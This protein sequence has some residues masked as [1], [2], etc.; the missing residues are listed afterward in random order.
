[1]ITLEGDTPIVVVTPAE[2]TLPFYTPTWAGA[3]PIL[4]KDHQGLTF[5]PGQLVFVY[6]EGLGKD[7]KVSITLSHAEQGQLAQA[8]TTSDFTGHASVKH[9]VR[10]SAEA[11]GARPAGDLTFTLSTGDVSESLTFTIDYQKVFEKP[12][13]AVGIS[14]TRVQSGTAVAFWCSGFEEGATITPALTVNGQA[15]TNPA[16]LFELNPA[17]SDGVVI[18]LLTVFE[19]DPKGIWTIQSGLES[20]RVSFKVE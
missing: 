4:T 15:A 11:E 6:A 19:Q 17:G 13:P 8:E 16:D 12:K 10:K 2:T 20:C 18:G 3:V 5:G 1:M 7:Q 9:L 14:A